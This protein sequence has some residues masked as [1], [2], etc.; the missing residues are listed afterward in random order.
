MNVPM[1]GLWSGRESTLFLLWAKLKLTV[2]L[3]SFDLTGVATM[4]TSIPLFSISPTFCVCVANPEV[5]DNGT[6]NKSSS[7]FLLYQSMET[8]NRLF[9]TL[10]SRPILSGL[11]TS[12]D[13]SR[14]PTFP[15]TLPG[16]LL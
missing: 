11:F 2:Q 1:I 14:F 8:F 4:V 16:M 3:K 5:G 10:T 6:F 15:G 13:R 12:H 9:N 7:D